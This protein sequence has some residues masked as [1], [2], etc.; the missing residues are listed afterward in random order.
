MGFKGYVFDRQLR[1]DLTGY[2]YK[3][4]GLQLSVFDPLTVSQTTRNA[5]GAKVRGIELNGVVK[6]DTMR[7]LELRGSVAY[8]KAT[9]TDFIGGC[10]PGQ[11]IA[12]GCNLI[13][14]NPAR[15]PATEGT[16]API[17]RR[18][19]AASR[20]PARRNGR[21]PAAPAMSMTSATIWVAR[22]RSMRSTPAPTS[23]RSRPIRSRSRRAIGSWPA[24]SRSM[25]GRTGAGSS[26]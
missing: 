13:P 10:Y 12:Q 24:M 22:S 25:A 14:R 7:G 8:N 5:A 2:Y 18:T 21:S 1:F 16:A 3:Y 15:A 11:T 17:P 4:K 6:P 26:R 20:S 19:R 23:R 9:Y